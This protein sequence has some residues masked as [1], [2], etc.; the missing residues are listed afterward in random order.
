[1]KNGS[2]HTGKAHVTEMFTG[3]TGSICEAYLRCVTLSYVVARTI[4]QVLNLFS[5][6]SKYIQISVTLAVLLGPTLFVFP[7]FVCFSAALP[8]CIN[9]VAFLHS[10]DAQI[11]IVTALSIFHNTCGLCRWES[12]N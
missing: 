2:R 12:G 10:F 6:K 3:E 11:N 8:C 7:L 9:C 1:M 5:H 4:C